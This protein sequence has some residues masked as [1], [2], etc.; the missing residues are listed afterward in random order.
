MKRLVLLPLF[1]TFLMIMGVNAQ[2]NSYNMVLEMTNGTRINTGPN[3]VQ[4]ISF[5]DGELTISGTSI[6]EI[7]NDIKAIKERLEELALTISNN[8]TSLGYKAE[9]FIGYWNMSVAGNSHSFIFLPNGKAIRDGSVTGEWTYNEK[10][11][12]LATNIE[13][14]SF[15]ITAM[16]GNNWT[17]TTANTD[18]AVK[19]T[20]G[21]N[22]NYIDGYVRML[23]WQQENGTTFRISDGFYNYYSNLSDVISYYGISNII[24]D[25]ENG[26][27]SF[28]VEYEEQFN[29]YLTAKRK[30]SYEIQGMYNDQPT[31]IINSGTPYYGTWRR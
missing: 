16:F 4:N 1:A 18:R 20:K 15:N 7:K 5:T 22:N 6:E 27:A 19:A 28:E 31:L 12:V 14:W 2:N 8:S 17:A 29:K 25:A 10:S 3:D 26:N 13:M 21:D 23:V 24:I 11:N 9:D 30:D